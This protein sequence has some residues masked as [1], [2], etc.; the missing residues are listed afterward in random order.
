MCRF[1]MPVEMEN[2]RM[3]IR[4][5]SVF[6]A[7]VMLVTVLGGCS[8][9]KQTGGTDN[10]N[11]TDGSYD[12]TDCCMKYL[13]Y[14]GENLKNRD[15]T[16]DG[17]TPSED[18]RHQQTIDLIVGELK[19]AG[20][21]DSQIE[22][23]NFDCTDDYSGESYSGTNIVLSIEG[24]KGDTQIIAGS[25]YDGDGC[26]DNGSGIALLLGNAVSMADIVP[27]RDL[28]IVFFDAEEIGLFGSENYVE[29][30][31][32]QDIARTAYM[33]NI[34]AVAF[35]DYCNIYGGSADGDAIINLGAYDMAVEKAKTLGINV[36]K[37]EDLDGYFAANGKG[38][39]IADN[40]LY[41]NP[42]TAENPAPLNPGINSPSTGPW[43]DHTA[44]DEAG[45]P[46][47]Y[48]E[49][50]NWFAAGTDESLSYT[51]YYES[52]DVTLGDGGM[53][54]NTR[55]DTLDNLNRYF[56]GRA[57]AHFH[58]FSPLLQVLLTNPENQQ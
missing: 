32:S 56:P 40:T 6:A 17:Q 2:L 45:I 19:S 31:S 51:G 30:M 27:E 52:S 43:S 1:G 12:C 28:K 50:S 36:Y 11:Q 4:S 26:G 15:I 38:P 42:W 46:Y 18:N 55:Y 29:N 5:L 58:V 33:I 23:Q 35:G 21:S 3:K 44:F 47:V 16:P 41:T 13:N 57:S 10:M 48:F 14:I 49:A 37:T 7:C 53:F 20:Y 9:M 39:E 22:L 24:S 25:H 8:I 34:D 54:M